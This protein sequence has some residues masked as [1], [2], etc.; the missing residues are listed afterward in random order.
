MPIKG[1]RGGQFKLSPQRHAG[2][3]ELANWYDFDDPD[4][5]NDAVAGAK[6]YTEAKEMDVPISGLRALNEIDKDRARGIMNSIK[7]SGFDP[8]SRIEVLGDA[9]GGIVLD[10]NHRAVAAAASGMRTVPAHVYDPDEIGRW[11]DWAR[12]YNS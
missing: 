1:S 11:V 3:Q 12:E 7:S 8:N 9:E 10:G 6:A 2:T 5:A 4:E